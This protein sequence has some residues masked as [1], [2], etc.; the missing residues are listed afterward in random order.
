M[1]DRIVIVDRET[2][3]G[4][5]GADVLSPAVSVLM[6]AVE[7]GVAR[8]AVQ[9]EVGLGSESPESTPVFG[10]TPVLIQ[11]AKLPL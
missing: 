5:P 4:T 1:H 10:S 9:T 2:Q 3:C 8:H 6:P 7:E 11:G